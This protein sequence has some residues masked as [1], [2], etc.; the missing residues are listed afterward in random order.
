M[1]AAKTLTIVLECKFY[2]D[3]IFVLC[4]ILFTSH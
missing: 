4:E 2:V 3:D 1:R